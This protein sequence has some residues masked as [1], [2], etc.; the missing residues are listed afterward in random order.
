MKCLQIINSPD[1]EVSNIISF[2]TFT[3]DFLHGTALYQKPTIGPTLLGGLKW[4]K[5][6]FFFYL[7][8]SSENITHVTRHIVN[9]S[10][11]FLLKE[12]LFFYEENK[13]F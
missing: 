8:L 6:N 11:G 7:I 10:Q 9:L 5:A 1:E 3:C 2:E 13:F 12:Q 4:E